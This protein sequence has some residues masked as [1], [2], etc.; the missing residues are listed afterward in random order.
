M[1]MC[2][3]VTVVTA[4]SRALTDGISM[5]IIGVGA[6]A[7]ETEALKASRTGWKGLLEPRTDTILRSNA[8]GLAWSRAMDV[9]LMVDELTADWAMWGKA[10]KTEMVMC[11]P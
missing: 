7:S 6:P 1:V 11:W 10:T 5:Y 2:W 4:P 3:P 9:M 8:P